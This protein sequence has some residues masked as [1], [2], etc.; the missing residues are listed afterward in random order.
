MKTNHKINPLILAVTVLVLLANG[1][2]H[3]DNI[4]V[5]SYIGGTIEKFDWSGNRTT[6]ASCLDHSVGL[7]FDSSGNL[8]VGT[9]STI[10]KFDSSGNKSTFASGLPSTNGLAFAFDSSGYLYA[11]SYGNGT[12]TRFDS[13]GN[14]TIFVSSVNRPH[15]LAF[16]SSGYLYA[17]NHG[18]GTITKF[19]SSGN[20]TIF[21]SGLDTPIFIAT[22]VPEPA[23][24][25]IMTL[26][27]LFIA[28][29]RRKR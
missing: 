29:K 1:L 18:N 10:E 6:F 24:A 23:S 25:A 17:V 7:A 20:G 19:D 8:Y 26:A 22:Q 9:S 21:A 13:S 5:S 4:Y 2:A 16:D 28:L 15:G 12:I 14:G 3:A 11:A 27:G